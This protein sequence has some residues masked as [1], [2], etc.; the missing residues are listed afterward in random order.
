MKIRKTLKLL[1]ITSLLFCSC[2]SNPPQSPYVDPLLL[3]PDSELNEYIEA[4]SE[5]ELREMITLIE[6]EVMEKKEKI[7]LQKTGTMEE[8]RFSW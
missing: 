1:F 3:M 8:V 2:K 7:I 4:L 6:Q 5:G